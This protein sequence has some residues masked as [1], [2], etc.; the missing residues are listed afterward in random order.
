MSDY[1]V[2]QTQSGVFFICPDWTQLLQADHQFNNEHLIGPFLTQQ[3][4]I[5]W[6]LANLPPEISDTITEIFEASSPRRNTPDNCGLLA[7][8]YIQKISKDDALDL[9]REQLIS[10]YSQEPGEFAADAYLFPPLV[11]PAAD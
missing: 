8:L 6:H 4:A 2:D 1:T 7:D 5:E 10:E 9:Y 3:V 11:D